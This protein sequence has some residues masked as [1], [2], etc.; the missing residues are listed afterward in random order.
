[1]GRSAVTDLHAVLAGVSRVGID[2]SPFIYLMEAHSDYLP[3]VA[4]LFVRM[5]SGE[6][7]AVTSTITVAE[8]TVLPL[9]LHRNDLREQYL[10]LLLNSVNLDVIAIDVHVAQVAAELR[11][12]FAIRLP[13]ALQLAA[14]MAAG[15]DAFVTNDRALKQVTDL[16]VIVLADLLG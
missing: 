16:S 7:S 10:N 8:V 14:A 6:I 9:R 15:C 3:L 1:M 2:T 5:D 11:A 4:P 13:D 12:Q